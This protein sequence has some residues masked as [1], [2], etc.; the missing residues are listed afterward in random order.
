MDVG[1][2][3]IDMNLLIKLTMPEGRMHPDDS[4][5]AEPSLEEKVQHYLDLIDSG[6]ESQREW[7]FIKKLNNKLTHCYQMGKLQ[8]GSKQLRI[9][10]MIQPIIEK[11]GQMDPEG[12]EQDASLH[13]VANGV[14]E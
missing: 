10:K 1:G 12:V 11:Y 4:R 5:Y 2:D 14:K 6:H 8:E 9:L 7:D 3:N 13:S